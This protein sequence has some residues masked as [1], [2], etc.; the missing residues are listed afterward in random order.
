MVWLIYKPIIICGIISAKEYGTAGIMGLFILATLIIAFVAS[1]A[2]TWQEKIK[3]FCV[4]FVLCLFFVSP[5]V[6][7]PLVL[8]LCLVYIFVRNNFENILGLAIIAA[9]LYGG[10]YLL[11]DA[12]P[13]FYNYLFG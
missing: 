3:T 6:V 7:G 8:V 9:L 5:W 12:I 10:Y 2:P 1:F 4:I 11:F 13:D